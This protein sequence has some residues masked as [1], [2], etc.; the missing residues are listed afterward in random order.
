MSDQFQ[1]R[2]PAKRS[3]NASRTPRGPPIRETPPTTETSQSSDHTMMRKNEETVKSVRRYPASRSRT[4]QTHYV[5]NVDNKSE[6]VDFEHREGITDQRRS[7]H[8]SSDNHPPGNLVKSDLVQRGNKR[9][10]RKNAPKTYIAPTDIS[11]DSLV[12]PICVEKFEELELRFYPCPCGYR[13]CAM[14]IHLIREK[15]DGKCPNC[16]ELYVEDRQRLASE[17]EKGLARLLRQVSKEEERE[18]R[19]VFP[20]PQKPKRPPPRTYSEKRLDKVLA[21]HRFFPKSSEKST[22][23]TSPVSTPVPEVKLSRFS[24][25]MSV[26]D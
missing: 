6:S 3:P 14:C 21:N 13:V 18:K 19:L 8:K 9:G 10:M 20:S 4:K 26:W 5:S 11:R 2:G 1:E 22:K 15:A 16:R 25:G 23:E 24:G 7:I 17:I 12:C